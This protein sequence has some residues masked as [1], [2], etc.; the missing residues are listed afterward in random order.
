MQDNLKSIQEAYI[1]SKRTDLIV[2]SNKYPAKVAKC[3]ETAHKAKDVALSNIKGLDS[4]KDKEEIRD[5]WQSAAW[6][7]DSAHDALDSHKDDLIEDHT[8]H[9]K[10]GKYDEARNTLSQIEQTHK[11]MQVHLN[12]DSHKQYQAL[13]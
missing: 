6:A 8:H 5:H 7:H 13:K 2:E 3:I 4:V 10:T 12:T 1:S 11:D 9:L